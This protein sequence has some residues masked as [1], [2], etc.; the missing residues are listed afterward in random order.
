MNDSKKKIVFRIGILLL[1]AVLIAGVIL[2]RPFIYK[3]VEFFPSCIFNDMFNLYCP[4]CGNT[5]S[6]LALLRGDVFAALKYNITPPLLLIIGG[7]GYAE[8]VTICF[9]RHK[10]ILPRSNIFLFSL[11]G[12][13]LVYYVIRNFFI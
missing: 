3:L 11:V 2:L 9:K 12:L 5:R 10:K 6:V 4:A 7:L 13:L 1:P 8:L